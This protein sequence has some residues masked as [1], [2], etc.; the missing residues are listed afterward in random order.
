MQSYKKGSHYTPQCFQKI[1]SLPSSEGAHL[2]SI[3]DFFL[4]VLSF[5]C[6]VLSLVSHNNYTTLSQC[7]P[8]IPKHPIS[9][10]THLKMTCQNCSCNCCIT[11]GVKKRPSSDLTHF[12][13][14][15]RKEI[16]EKVTHFVNSFVIISVRGMVKNLPLLQRAGNN[17]HPWVHAVMCDNTY[18]DIC[19]I[20]HTST[21]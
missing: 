19:M 9:A 1:Q 2:S 14:S 17:G 6:K 4:H 5:S 10:I 16:F 20:I 11:Q 21:L 8:F 12:I 13:G 15:Y 3:T 7:V 18:S